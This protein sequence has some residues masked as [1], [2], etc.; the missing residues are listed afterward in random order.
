MSET[1]ESS[2]IQKKKF[3]DFSLRDP[4]EQ[5]DFLNTTWCNHCMEA[6]LGMVDPVEYELEGR[7]FLEGKCRKCGSI[8]TTEI[9]EDDQELDS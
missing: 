8:V 4:E 1:H 2:D 9:I 5:S 6:D 3:R 7:V